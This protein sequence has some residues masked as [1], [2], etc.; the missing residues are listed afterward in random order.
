MSTDTE[1]VQ[2]CT[3][4]ARTIVYRFNGGHPE[5][6][7]S[8]DREWKHCPELWEMTSGKLDVDDL[9]EDVASVLIAI[10]V[11]ERKPSND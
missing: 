5:H 1:K 4:V 9:S 11:E 6:Y 2:Y 3:N 8:F 7:D 10:L